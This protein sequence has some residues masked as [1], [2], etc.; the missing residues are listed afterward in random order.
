MNNR[1]S[2][3]QG[4]SYSWVIGGLPIASRIG[5][6]EDMLASTILPDSVPWALTNSERRGE[7]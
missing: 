6:L 4:L 2:K 1:S 5:V 3:G 7:E